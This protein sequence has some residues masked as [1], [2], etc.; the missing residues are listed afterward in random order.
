M[1]SQCAA[2][3]QPLYTALQEGALYQCNLASHAALRGRLARVLQ[4]RRVEE[5]AH[6]AALALEY[7]RKF[8]HW[9]TYLNGHTRSFSLP[10]FAPV[11]EHFCT[12]E[13]AC[14]LAMCLKL[15]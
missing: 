14:R 15:L 2:G 7:R 12:K 1:L 6:E 13:L 5:R 9:R 4:M 11:C 3:A 8:E 10:K